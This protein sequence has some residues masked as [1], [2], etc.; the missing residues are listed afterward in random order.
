[1]IF[2]VGFLFLVCLLA[3]RTLGQIEF[4]HFFVHVEEEDALLILNLPPKHCGT[5]KDQ[6]N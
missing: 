2:F 3:S 4:A 1:V 5:K 6:Q